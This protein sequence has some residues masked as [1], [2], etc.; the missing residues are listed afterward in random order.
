MIK[1]F[2]YISNYNYILNF[3]FITFQNLCYLNYLSKLIL[4]NKFIHKM[5]IYFIQAI[6][7]TLIIQ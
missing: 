2:I 5:R 6:I 7:F 1:I 3:I 4:A